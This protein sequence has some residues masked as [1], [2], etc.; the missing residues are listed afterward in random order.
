MKMRWLLSMAAAAALLALPAQ[1]SPQD[2]RFTSSQTQAAPVCHNDRPIEEYLTE[3]KKSKKQRNKNPFPTGACVGS[4]CVGKVEKPQPEKLPPPSLP[5]PKSDSGTSE[6]SS[7]GNAGGAAMSAAPDYDPLA[8]AQSVD[9]GDYYFSEK[10]YRAAL[11]R[12]QEA[13]ESKPD[14]SAIYIR[15]GRAFD[16]LGQVTRAFE[17]YDAS[18]AADAA[19]PFAQEAR[20]AVERLRPDVKKNGDDP[21][22]ISARNRARIVPPCPKPAPAS[23]HPAH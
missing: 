6:S 13:L 7:R 18:L 8:A 12:Y 4:L 5:Q 19:G 10:N 1:S 15:L 9:V 21:D 22:A 3:L 16:R 23:L 14:D 2:S 20:K 11:S 17:D